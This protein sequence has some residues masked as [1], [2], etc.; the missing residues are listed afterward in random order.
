ME[1]SDGTNLK[2][3]ESICDREYQ[4]KNYFWKQIADYLIEFMIMKIAGLIQ[5][6]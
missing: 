2:S 3:Y 4:S 1:S 6:N 5:K